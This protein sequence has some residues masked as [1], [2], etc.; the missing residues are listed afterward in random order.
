MVEQVVHSLC[1]TLE[2]LYAWWLIYVRA[3]MP[4]GLYAF[5]LIYV[6]GYIVLYSTHCSPHFPMQE[7]CQLCLAPAKPMQESCQVL[8]MQGLARIM[9]VLIDQ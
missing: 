5:G 6:S 3:Y 4:Y 7:S 9:P 1:I 2:G 8:D